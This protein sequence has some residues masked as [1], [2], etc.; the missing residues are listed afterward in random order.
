M[1]HGNNTRAMPEYRPWVTAAAS[2]QLAQLREEHRLRLALELLERTGVRETGDG[3]LYLDADDVPG[4]GL[5]D[6]L[7][8]VRAWYGWREMRRLARA[9]DVDLEL[10]TV[11]LQ[12]VGHALVPLDPDGG[13]HLELDAGIVRNGLTPYDELK[14]AMRRTRRARGKWDPRQVGQVPA[15]SAHSAHSVHSAHSAHPTHSAH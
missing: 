1:R 5:S 14:D 8:L 7:G 12:S 15:H 13:R 10:A 6:L 11:V 2:S 9:A 4:A 3:R